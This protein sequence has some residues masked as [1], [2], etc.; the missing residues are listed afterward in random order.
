M[1]EHLRNE[2]EDVAKEAEICRQRTRHKRVKRESYHHRKL[3]NHPFDRREKNADAIKDFQP[4]HFGNLFRSHS[5]LYRPLVP[6]L[7]VI[8]GSLYIV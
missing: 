5:F 3:T 4:R 8:E 2:R 6:P 1:V 7:V